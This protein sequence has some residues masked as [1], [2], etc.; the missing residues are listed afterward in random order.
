MTEI[1]DV[2]Q[3][4]SIRIKGLEGKLMQFGD[5]LG[6]SEIGLLACW[7]DGGEYFYLPLLE[8]KVFD[9]FW[10]LS[11]SSSIVTFFL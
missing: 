6:G 7:S 11:L 9:Y 5:V 2:I 8:W 3:S 10:R 1:D 4:L